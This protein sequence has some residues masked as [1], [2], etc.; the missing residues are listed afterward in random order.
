MLVDNV[1]F[2]LNGYTWGNEWFG[3]FTNEFINLR[4]LFSD[5]FF[6]RSLNMICLVILNG[7]NL[8]YG[9]WRIVTN[10]RGVRNI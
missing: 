8:A 1:R 7:V 4:S 5:G 2:I 6:F 3:V 9:G 10:S